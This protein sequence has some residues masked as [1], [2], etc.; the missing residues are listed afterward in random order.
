MSLIF[1]GVCGEEITPVK[2]GPIPYKKIDIFIAEKKWRIEV[3]DDIFTSEE[4]LG[5]GVPDTT[6]GKIIQAI[7][8]NP[9]GSE[10]ILRLWINEE[11]QVILSKQSWKTNEGTEHETYHLTRRN[12]RQV[13]IDEVAITTFSEGTQRAK[14]VRKE[15][16]IEVG[17]EAKIEMIYKLTDMERETKKRTKRIA[18]I[19]MTIRR[20]EK[21]GITKTEE[22]VCEQ[23]KY[24]EK[25]IRQKIRRKSWEDAEH[26]IV[27]AIAE[28][29]QITIIMFEADTEEIQKQ[30]KTFEIQE[31]FEITYKVNSHEKIQISKIKGDTSGWGILKIELVGTN[32]PRSVRANQ[33]G[34]QVLEG[35]IIYIILQLSARILEIIYKI[36][37]GERQDIGRE[38]T[39]QITEIEGR[40]KNGGEIGK[41]QT[42]QTT[43][44][45]TE[46]E[47]EKDFEDEAIKMIREKMIANKTFNTTS[48]TQT[49]KKPAKEESYVIQPEIKSLLI[50]GAIL[51][52]A[53]IIILVIVCIY[54]ANRA[55]PSL[56]IREE[57]RELQPLPCRLSFGELED[58]YALDNTWNRLYHI[59]KTPRPTEY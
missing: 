2:Q 21:S 7:E 54:R 20:T 48:K 33:N 6:E 50:T 39:R 26:K 22:L 58:E 32:K 51:T 9:I 10:D 18:D 1:K 8:I 24:Q 31:D 3:T 15:I 29:N 17:A 55:Y 43:T 16:P 37:T 59:G 52:G 27:K 44:I 36:E 11:E 14:T 45:S 47:P 38:I 35:G 57:V 46:P 56:E 30:E 41:D 23:D 19:R 13:K 34:R 40:I 12:N 25:L 42:T 49:T 5:T 28:R 53:L 4:K